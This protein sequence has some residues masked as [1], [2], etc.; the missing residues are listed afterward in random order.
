MP[1]VLSREGLPILTDFAQGKGTP[2]VI[3][4]DNGRGYVL[5]DDNEIVPVNGHA[6]Y[7]NDYKENTTPGTTDMRSAIN[8]AMT[9]ASDGDVIL[10]GNERYAISATVTVSKRLRFQGGF[11]YGDLLP[12]LAGSIIQGSGTT[13]LNFT[14][15]FHMDSMTV[16]DPTGHASTIGVKIANGSQPTAKWKMSNCVLMS[17]VASGYG[18]LG[19]GLQGQFALEGVVENCTIEGWLNGIDW[20]DVSGAMSNANDVRGCKI[21]QNTIGVLL[22]GV[23]N[24]FLNGNTIEGN[25][26]GLK[27]MNGKAVATSNHFENNLGDQREIHVV[28]GNLV[29]VANGYYAAGGSDQDIYIESGS[30]VHVSVGDTLNRG[31]KHTGSGLFSLQ[32][33]LLTPIVS[34]TGP[35]VRVDGFGV[36]SLQGSTDL[37]LTPGGDIKWG[38]ALVALGGGAAPTLGTIGGSG[39]AT[40]GQNS[41][42]RMLDSTGASMWIPVWK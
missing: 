36:I 35:I 14:K 37:L 32:M 10:F 21:R 6:F 25:S 29:S 42:L 26:T 30:G 15:P 8:D 9:D 41:W 5:R 40:A 18:T 20:D 39:P 28:D 13:L 34:G 33:P 3:N 24:A 12:T 1:E 7:V 22:S 17:F 2:L 19:T 16:W 4:V 11:S 27:V 38:K 23:D 31:I